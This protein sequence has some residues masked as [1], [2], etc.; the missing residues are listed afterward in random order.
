MSLL[1]RARVDEDEEEEGTMSMAVTSTTGVMGKGELVQ[2]VK[3]TSGLASPIVSLAGGHT[4]SRGLAQGASHGQW[5]TDATVQGE[6]LACRFDPSGRRIAACSTDRCICEPTDA[7][8]SY[9]ADGCA[10]H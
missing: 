10:P 2:S 4:V 9:K 6:I 5:M 7:A 3:R 1:K 8:T